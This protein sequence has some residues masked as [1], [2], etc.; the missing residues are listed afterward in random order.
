MPRLNAYFS[1]GFLVI[2]WFQFKAF[3][4]F[5]Y[6][7]FVGCYIKAELKVVGVLEVRTWSGTG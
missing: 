6:L 5:W 1:Y 4:S 2:M 3:S 7:V